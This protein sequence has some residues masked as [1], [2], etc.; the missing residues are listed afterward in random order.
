MKKYIVICAGL[1]LALSFTGC[2]S[3]ESAYKLA[4]DR[5]KAQEATVVQEVEPTTTVV[6]PVQT[7]TV[8]PTASS[9]DNND[10]VNVR[11][12]KLSVVNGDGLQDFSVVVGSYGLKAN[13]EG[14]VAKLRSQGYNAQLAYNAERGMYRVVASTFASKADAVASRDKFRAYYPDAWL[15]YNIK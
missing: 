9:Y 2:K 15:L 4:Y 10:N 8:A 14:M 5:A 11:Q 7:T 6:A 1:C 12:E 3:S 13:A